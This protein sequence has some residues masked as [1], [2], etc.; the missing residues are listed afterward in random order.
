MEKEIRKRDA[1]TM[2]AAMCSN[3]LMMANLVLGYATQFDFEHFLCGMIVRLAAE[4]EVR[5]VVFVWDKSDIHRLEG[6]Y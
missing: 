4:V 1:L 6:A 5:E 3:G 2:I